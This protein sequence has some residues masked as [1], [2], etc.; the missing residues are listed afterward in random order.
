MTHRGCRLWLFLIAVSMGMVNAPEAHAGWVRK[1]AV[2]LGAAIVGASIGAAITAPRGNVKPDD[3]GERSGSGVPSTADSS[4]KPTLVERGELLLLKAK[5]KELRKNLAA[6]GEQA[7]KGCAAHHIVPRADNR[8]FL[9]G[10][11]QEAREI[12][13]ACDI[14]IDSAINGVYLPY[15]DDAQ[16]SGAKHVDLHTESYYRAVVTALRSALRGGC[17][18]VRSRLSGLKDDLKA[19]R[20]TKMGY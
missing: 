20:L 14:D 8:S 3:F 6:N 16:C 9:N 1:G 7:K 11:P 17:D 12:L 4:D 2:G 5:T 19:G 13:G 15:E 18:K 10:A